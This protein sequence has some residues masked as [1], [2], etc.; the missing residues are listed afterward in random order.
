M[1]SNGLDALEMEFIEWLFS[2]MI[3]ME[4]ISPPGHGIDEMRHMGGGY[5]PAC[6]FQGQGIA[7][8]PFRPC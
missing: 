4:L 5:M 3:L 6:G 1:T 2:T 7:F 8:S